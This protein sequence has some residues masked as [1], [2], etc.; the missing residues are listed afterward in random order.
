ME[1]YEQRRK[2]EIF[3]I[4]HGSG[5][6]FRHRSNILPQKEH[7]HIAGSLRPYC[8]DIHSDTKGGILSFILYGANSLEN[9]IPLENQ[10]K[11]I[12]DNI[13]LDFKELLE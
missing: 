9:T 4:P 2:F 5:N 12:V 8:I 7:K 10:I 13:E 3:R 1:A 6:G 11:H